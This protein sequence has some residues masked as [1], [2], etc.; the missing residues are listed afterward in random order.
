M[1]RKP[2]YQA[3]HSYYYLFQWYLFWFYLFC[4]LHT[5]PAFFPEALGSTYND[6]SKEAGFM[7]QIY[8]CH[9]P[10]KDTIF[11]INNNYFFYHLRKRK[12]FLPLP[13]NICPCCNT[14]GSID[15]I[16]SIRVRGKVEQ[17]HSVV[18]LRRIFFRIRK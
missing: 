8:F 17:H 3:L 10:N 12:V 9:Q 6:R 13:L 1:D 18:Q 15:T 14:K 4:I 5:H 16:Y 2:D 11:I 7:E